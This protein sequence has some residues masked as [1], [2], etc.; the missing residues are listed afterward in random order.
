MQ[1]T[2]TSGP[3]RVRFAPSPTGYL[4]IGG[5][6]TALFNWLIA[7]QSGGAFVLRIEDTDRARHVHDSVD[8]ICDDLRWLGLEWDEGPAVGGDRGPYFQS[9]RLDIYR[10]YE[11]KLL[12][13]GLAYH[14]TETPD[15]LTAMREQARAEKRA[16][17]YPR[18]DPLPSEADVRRARDEGRP[19]V[20]RFKMPAEDVTVA[21]RILGDVTVSK[22]ELEDFVIVKSDGFPTYHFACVIDDELMQITDVLRG[23]EHLMNT[24]KHI[25]MQKAMGFRTPRYAHV[26][27]I[28]NAD[29]SK[30]SK[31]DKE[32]ALQK[33]IAPPE[34]DV[35]DFRLAGYLP[36]VVINFIA[37]LG[38][39]P[40]GDREKL[41]RD[42]LVSLFDPT[43]IG[44][45][46]ARFDRDKLLAFNTDALN[47]LDEDARLAAWKAHLA[48][49]GGPMAGARDD[50]LRAV[51]RASEGFRT[52][53]ELADKSRFL[54]EPND[55]IQFDEAA[56]TKV[57]RKGDPNGI[58]V[59][60]QLVPRLESVEPWTSE[61]IEACL[62]DACEALGLGLGKVAQPVRVAV[63]GTTISPPIFDT[64]AI[65]GR[66]ATI[67]RAKRCLAQYAGTGGP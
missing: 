23:Q 4:H 16:F 41:T 52:F 9:E 2:T 27:L 17:K 48:V 24:P 67:H 1:T 47:A 36:E 20:V 55:A 53:V 7:R 59:L 64:L 38:W 30:M 25:A 60:T 31:R 34:I 62:R 28:F 15:E 6:R 29:G 10:E 5:A 26:P 63:S 61:A 43:R 56:V 8:K 18:P 22:D 51:L 65:L 46:A 21:D 11:R 66:D 40:G 13:N 12:E 35:H 42:E 33:G 39:S 49:A 57:L 44:K 32:K 19:V 45:T 37:L 54:F 58:A 14:A 3:C 50:K